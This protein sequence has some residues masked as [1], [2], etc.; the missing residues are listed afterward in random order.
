LKNLVF[1]LDNHSADVYNIRANEYPPKTA[2]ADF[3]SISRRGE[4]KAII[5]ADHKRVGI[6]STTMAYARGICGENS[7]IHHD[8]HYIDG[9]EFNCFPH[10]HINL[11]DNISGDGHSWYSYRFK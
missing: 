8:P 11:G 1:T 3:G 9:K 6:R 2:G 5:G 10:Y 7:A 4:D